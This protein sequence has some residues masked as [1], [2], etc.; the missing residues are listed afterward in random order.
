[1]GVVPDVP[2]ERTIKGVREGRDEYLEKALEIAR[3]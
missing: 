3:Q 1:V 2:V